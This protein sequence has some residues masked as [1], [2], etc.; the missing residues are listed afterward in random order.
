MIEMGYLDY[1]L[2]LDEM[3]AN[4]PLYPTLLRSQETFGGQCAILRT[5]RTHFNMAI[6]LSWNT[7]LTGPRC[8]AS[9]LTNELIIG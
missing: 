2:S 3:I 7:R 4:K 8:Q 6:N 1:I 5:N 9:E